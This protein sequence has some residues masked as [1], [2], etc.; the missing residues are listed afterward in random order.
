MTATST[1]HG[2]RVGPPR[3]FSRMRS[4]AGR[5]WLGRSRTVLVAC[6]CSLLIAGIAVAGIF[7]GS[8]LYRFIEGNQLKRGFGWFVLVIGFYI[9]FK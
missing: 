8:Y 1:K 7:V 3:G 6:A 9:I 5:R 4:A 2:D